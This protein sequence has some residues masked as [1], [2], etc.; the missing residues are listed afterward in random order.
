MG[1]RCTD[2]YLV[3][4]AGNEWARVYTL[5]YFAVLILGI[6]NILEAMFDKTIQRPKKDTKTLFWVLT[7]YLSFLVAYGN[8]VYNVV[9]SSTRYTFGHVRFY[10]SVRLNPRVQNI[11]S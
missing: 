5:F 9:R 6:L 1:A 4:I 7:G 11:A 2:N 10:A 8:R 3:F